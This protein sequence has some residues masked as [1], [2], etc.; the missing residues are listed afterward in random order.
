MKCRSSLSG[1]ISRFPACLND[2]L[3]W[4]IE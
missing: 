1:W 2:H 4:K 3:F